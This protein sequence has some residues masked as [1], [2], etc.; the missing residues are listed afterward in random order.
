M[1]VLVLGGRGFIGRHVVDALERRGHDVVVGTRHAGRR[2]GAGRPSLPTRFEDLVTCAAWC[3]LVQCF[4]VVVNCVGIL[5]ERPGETFDAVHHRSPAALCAACGEVGVRHLIHVS[6]LGLGDCARNGFLTSKRDGERALRDPAV[7]TTV[8][9]PSLLDGEGGFGARWLRRL[10]RLP[11][12][13]VPA[14]AIGRIAAVDVGDVGLAIA[15]LCERAPP[16]GL[17]EVELGGPDERTLAGHLAALRAAH[18]RRPAVTIRVPSVL[19]RS[20][21]RV[22]DRLHFSPYSVGHLE[23]LRGD[24]VPRVDHLAALLGRPPVRVGAAPGCPSERPPANSFAKSSVKSSAK[25]SV[26]SSVQLAA[27]LP[28][29]SPHRVAFGAPPRQSVGPGERG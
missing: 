29:R 5:R 19:A 20:A 25:S 6:A 21:A 15:H 18:H 1:K 9:R 3:P 26:M 28:G 12:H 24:N 11:I 16:R 7:P 8:V 23:L 22:C 14:E 10:A 27:R 2:S 17:R 13:F 4:D